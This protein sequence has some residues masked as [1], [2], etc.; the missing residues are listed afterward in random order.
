MRII[1]GSV[2]GLQLATPDNCQIRPT[3][4]RV[5]EA[6]FS[7]LTCQLDGAR[8][9]DLYSGTG[10]NGL[11]ALSRGASWCDF[12]DW[13]SA[14][15]ALTQRNIELTRFT[16]KSKVW[17]LSLPAGLNRI[18]S[19]DSPY[20]L[21]FADPPY[22]YRN[23][24]DLLGNVIANG[25]LKS[26]GIMVLEHEKRSAVDHAIEGLECEKVRHYGDTTLACF[27]LKSLPS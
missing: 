25:L 9:L 2:K 14:S 24:S 27:G 26:S 1:A 20:D 4:D 11:E 21:I 3:S 22:E 16:T 13:D 7:I 19:I 10:A 15:V 6:L 8:F 17:R 18:K 12:V 5:R 23:Y